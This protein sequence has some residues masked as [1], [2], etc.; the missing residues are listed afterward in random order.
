MREHSP[1]R[2]LDGITQSLCE[3]Q[4]VCPLRVGNNVQVC[5]DLLHIP[6]RR[7]SDRNGNRQDVLARRHQASGTGSPRGLLFRGSHRS[8]RAD[9]TAYGSSE[10][11]FATCF[12]L[13]LF[14]FEN[15]VNNLGAGQ[16]HPITEPIEL[17]PDKV[18]FVFS[19]VQPSLP[20]AVHL[21]K[22]FAE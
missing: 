4:A 12:L 18:A 3:C 7:R 5:I 8:V 20:T 16:W 19:A 17:L 9:I 13:A 14:S 15:T 22:K 10:F 6:H 2:R 11:R 1:V 21:I